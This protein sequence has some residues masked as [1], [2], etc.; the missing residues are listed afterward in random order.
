[1]KPGNPARFYPGVTCSDGRSLSNVLDVSTLPL[2]VSRAVLSPTHDLIEKLY[3]TG[4][5]IARLDVSAQ[6]SVVEGKPLC[7]FAFKNSGLFE[8]IAFKSPST[9]EGEFNPISK[10]SNIGFG[11]GLLNN[12]DYDFFAMLG[13]Q[14]FLN[15]VD[16][17]DG[18]VEIPAGETR[19][20]DH[21]VPHD[22][23][24]KASGQPP[25][26]GPDFLL[27]LKCRP[28]LHASAKYGE[29]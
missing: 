14:E 10:S 11:G 6:F 26:H 9:W 22:R 21:E 28:F 18:I 25:N 19:Y 29:V 23:L 13:A 4:T 16:F 17:P 20:P 15:A 24:L 5:P 7:V 1:M 2:D 3:K 12:D 27:A 8:K